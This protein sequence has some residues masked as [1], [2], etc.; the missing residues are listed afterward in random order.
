MGYVQRRENRTGDI[1]VWLRSLGSMAYLILL[2]L[3]HHWIV[4]NQ[5][6]YHT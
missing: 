6:D 4:N 5:I 2:E 1:I 3:R